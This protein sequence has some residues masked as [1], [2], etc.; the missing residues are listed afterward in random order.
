[1]GVVGWAS[2]AVSG[3]GAELWICRVAFLDRGS[4]IEVHLL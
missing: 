4:S 3:T 2:R 1:M